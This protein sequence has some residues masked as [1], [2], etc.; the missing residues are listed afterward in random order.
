MLPDLT[1]RQLLLALLLSG[2]AIACPD[3]AYTK[4]GEESSGSGSSGS[5]DDD[6]DDDDDD[7]DGD[8]DDSEADEAKSAVGEGRAV[9]M[10]RL[11]Q[12]LKQNY[13]GRVLDVDLKRSSGRYHYRVK[14]LQPSGRVLRL[15]LDAVTLQRQG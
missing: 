2:A 10:R 15:R 6:H 7:D 12:H 1:R 9:S 5:G 13:P 4:D 11:L 3:A 8:D 14:V